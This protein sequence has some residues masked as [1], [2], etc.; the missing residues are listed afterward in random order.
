MAKKRGPKL[1]SPYRS[2]DDPKRRELWLQGFR[3]SGGSYAAA[4]RKA[5]SHLP[6]DSRNPPGYSSWKSLEARDPEWAA[7]VSETRQ[8]IQD[9]LEELAHRLAFGVKR[10]VHQKGG[11]VFEPKTDADGQIIR[12]AEGEPIMVPAEHVYHDSKI[13]LAK[14]RAIDPDK[15]GEK[16]EVN[17]NHRKAGGWEIS[18]EDIG[19][20]D[21]RLKQNLREVMEAIRRGRKQETQAIEHKPEENVN[22]VDVSYTEVTDDQ[23]ESWELAYDE[24]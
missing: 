15:W 6:G 7:L 18:T 5:G 13:V 22:V 17:I 14:L 1:N 24:D 2:T 21:D 19:F 3:E 9:D 11:L 8:Q 16:R 10:K 4:C 20:L 23:P 12:D